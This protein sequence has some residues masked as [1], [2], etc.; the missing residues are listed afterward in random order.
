MTSGRTSDFAG[1][2]PVDDSPQ[3]KHSVTSAG[4]AVP[5]CAQRHALSHG[6]SAV[7][8]MFVFYPGER[9]EGRNWMEIAGDD[10]VA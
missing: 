3:Y 9:G 4:F 5:H 10:A 6:P 2:P 7:P 1:R 8:L